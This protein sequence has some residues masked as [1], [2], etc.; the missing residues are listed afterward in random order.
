MKCFYHK[1]DLDGI[2][3]GAIIKYKYPECEMIGVDYGDDINPLDHIDLGK[4]CYVVDFA[5]SSEIMEKLFYKT[6]LIW[7]D[8]HK[9]SFDIVNKINNSH[10]IVGTTIHGKREIGKAGCELTWEYL[11]PER[12]MPEAIQLLGRYDVWDNSAEWCWENRTLPFQY[13]MKSLNRSVDSKFWHLLFS[14]NRQINKIVDKGILILVYQKEQN[15]KILENNY[16]EREFQGLKAICL[17]NQVYNSQ[18]FDSLW[19]EDKYDIMICFA[20]TG[21]HWKV[22]LYSTKDSVDCSELAKEFGGG[23]HKGAAGFI[24]IDNI[25]FLMNTG[26][27]G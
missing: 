5:F 19:D 23:G 8:H 12:E 1:S 15:K 21:K 22:S 2:C 25:S 27:P 4:E 9:S 11:F 3:S 26:I 24:L 14:D 13:G 6:H 16:F 10:G 20:Y 17:N 7:I 18:V